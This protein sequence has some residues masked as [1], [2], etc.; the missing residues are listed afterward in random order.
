MGDDETADLIPLR[1]DLE[2]HI[3]LRAVHGQI[4]HLVNHEQPI[5]HAETLEDRSQTVLL[6][7]SRQG[8]E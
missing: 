7:R 3:R 4:A 2:Q 6:L 1:R 5:S 8:D